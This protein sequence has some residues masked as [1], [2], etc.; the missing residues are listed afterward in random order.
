VGSVSAV[1]VRQFLMYDWLSN[2]GMAYPSGR[3]VLGVCWRQ[4]A[5]WNCGFE[6]SWGYGCLSVVNVVCC[7]VEVSALG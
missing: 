3:A 2:S 5:L 6:S 4:L 1:T 7:Q